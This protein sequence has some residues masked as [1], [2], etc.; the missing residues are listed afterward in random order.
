MLLRPRQK[1]FVERSIA[2]LDTHRN[3]LGV[4]PTASGK[5]IML[6][7]VAG[8]LIGERDA[9]ACVLAHRDELTD[10]NRTKFARVNP[11]ITTSVID[12]AEKSWNGQVAFAM[13]PTLA[14]PANLDAM[15]ALDLLV[16][17]EAHHAVAQSYRRIIDRATQRN[18]DVRI[19][20]VTATPNR[21]DK[22]GL[23]EVFDNV[24]DQIRIGELIASGHL[25]P[26]R[27]FV[28]DVGVQDELR[29]VHKSVADFDMNEVA[30][31]MDRAPITEEVIRHWME[32]AGE[33][34]T[35]VFCSTVAHAAHVTDAFQA[36]GVP[37][38]LIHGDLTPEL[39]RALL[40]SYARGS[41][42][43]V[44]NVAVLTEGWDH[45]PTS[46]VVLLRPSSFKSTMIQM[47]G[48][49][50]RTV[51]P[52]EHPG[53]AKTDCVILD[54]G[55]SSL[56][57]GSLEQDV[58]LDG[59]ELAGDAPTK[60]CPQCSAVVPAAVTECP[61]CG[62]VWES[63]AAGERA[64]P[65]GDFLMTEIDLLK[66]SSFEW[67][68][69]HGDGAALVA[70]GFTAWAGVFFLN[71][72]WYAVGG[73]QK[74]RPRLLSVG[75][76]M[77]GLAAAD[78]WLNTNESDESAHKTRS[79]LRQPATERQLAYLPPECRLDFSLTRYRASALL[80][81]RFNR[82]AIRSLVFGAAEAALA[83]A[84]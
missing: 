51:N 68:D 53:I 31:I 56:I 14:R 67:V 18:P 78:D 44:V 76:E 74:Q 17:D 61:L 43:V 21:G 46:C 12:A 57:H 26:P 48:R 59:R 62:H 84:A 8:A 15:P 82:S 9:K 80:T 7:A 81:F 36:A 83:A 24:A 79:W 72:R 25:V 34:Q 66:R 70:N 35:V 75:E 47:V 40:T 49:G 22:K 55:T 4:A 13:A 64:Q 30:G 1:L 29:S 58:D 2:A 32:K 60:T 27:T 63:M 28:I 5:T 38:A 39:R 11:A 69:L 73:A 50:L 65:L 23:R 33:R 42:R 52:E 10:Q 3:T 16:I 20:G 6:S 41:I 77:V 19:F 54:F 71:G 45:P 37:A